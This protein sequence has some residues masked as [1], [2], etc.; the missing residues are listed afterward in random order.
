MSCSNPLAGTDATL[1]ALSGAGYADGRSFGFASCER[2]VGAAEGMNVLMQRRLPRSNGSGFEYAYNVTNV[3]YTEFDRLGISEE[4]RDGGQMS[5]FPANTNVLYIG[6]QVTPHS[7]GGLIGL[8]NLS[9]Y[10]CWCSRLDRQ[11]ARTTFCLLE[12]L[13]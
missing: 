3:E 8:I 9:H 2:T 6:L 11:Q 10:C 12:L 13:Q 7:L 5:C 4:P 1:L